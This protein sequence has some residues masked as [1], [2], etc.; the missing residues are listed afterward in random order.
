M[1]LIC[2]IN[3]SALRIKWGSHREVFNPNGLRQLVAYVKTNRAT[4]LNGGAALVFL[5]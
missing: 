2:L 1:A 5:L 4:S 3:K